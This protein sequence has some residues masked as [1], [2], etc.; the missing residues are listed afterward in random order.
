MYLIFRTFVDPKNTEP[1]AEIKLRYDPESTSYYVFPPGYSKE[2]EVQLQ[3][4]YEHENSLPI[5]MI[6]DSAKPQI[7]GRYMLP[8]APIPGK[9]ISTEEEMTSIPSGAYKRYEKSDLP[10]KHFDSQFVRLEYL[11]GPLTA[12]KPKEPSPEPMPEPAR[13]GDFERE[14]NESALSWETGKLF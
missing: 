1:Q 4:E 14:R 6:M 13:E 5:G 12:V 10:L 7:D 9:I 11:P 8:F 3:I 2:V